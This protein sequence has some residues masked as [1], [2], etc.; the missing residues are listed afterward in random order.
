MTTKEES[1]YKPNTA[2]HLVHSHDVHLDD[3]YTR[4]LVELKAR[5]RSAQIKAAVK[6]NAEKLLF[7]WQLGRDLVI[8]RA[9]ERWGTGVVEQVSLDLHTE[10]PHEKGFSTRN[11]WY[12]S[13]GTNSIPESRNFCNGSLQK[14]RFLS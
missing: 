4:W 5:Y 1:N 3:D 7:N 12:M 10:F 2:P 6:V 9:E 8:K 11:L 13:N 14:Y